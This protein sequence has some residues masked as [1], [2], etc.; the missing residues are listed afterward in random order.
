[1]AW[2]SPLDTYLLVEGFPSAWVAGAY[3]L[4]TQIL[5]YGGDEIS[6]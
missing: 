5:F 6:I 4:I 3:Q 1:V 2:F